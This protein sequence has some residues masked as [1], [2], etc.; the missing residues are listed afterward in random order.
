AGPAGAGRPKHRR[1]WWGGL[2]HPPADRSCWRKPR[3]AMMTEAE[4]LARRQSRTSVFDLWGFERIGQVAT[5]RQF[6]LFAA[7]CCRRIWHLMSDDRARDAIETLEGF[8]DGLRT[9]TDREAV[10]AALLREGDLWVGRSD[11]PARVMSAAVL[12]AGLNGCDNL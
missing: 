10:L 2:L 5:D 3:G 6:R 1:R 7:C 11:S 9:D 12:C 8:A 4:W